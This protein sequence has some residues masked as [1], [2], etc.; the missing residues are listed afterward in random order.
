MISISISVKIGDNCDEIADYAEKLQAVLK[1]R[2]ILATVEPSR[3][4]GRPRN[5]ATPV[6]PLDATVAPTDGPLAT[7]YKMKRAEAGKP[8]SAIYCKNGMSAEDSAKFYLMRDYSYSPEFCG[9]I[10]D[11]GASPSENAQVNPLPM[12]NKTLSEEDAL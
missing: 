6:G 9:L 3:G 11:S 4:P 7:H 5:P 2:G 8:I 10:A 1:D 12:S